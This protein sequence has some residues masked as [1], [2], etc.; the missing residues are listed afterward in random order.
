MLQAAT[1]STAKLLQLTDFLA[2]E[3]RDVKKRSTILYRRILTAG[4]RLRKTTGYVSNG[5][6]DPTHSLTHLIPNN[7]K[8]RCFVTSYK[9]YKD[10][11]VLRF[12]HC[13]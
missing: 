6:T 13:I 7:G 12:T 3:M 11:Y 9:L 8:S 2:T 5:I 10:N 1:F 4:P